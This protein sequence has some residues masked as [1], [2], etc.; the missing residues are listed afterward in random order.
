MADKKKSEKKHKAEKKSR[1]PKAEKK[2][3]VK[4]VKK[5]EEPEVVI[6]RLMM[7]GAVFDD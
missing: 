1:Q 5:A 4:K 6:E 7:Q 2:P 3:S